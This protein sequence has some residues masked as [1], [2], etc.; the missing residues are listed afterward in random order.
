M[1]KKKLTQERLKELL[2]YDTETGFFTWRKIEVKNQVK[3]GDIAG[4]LS[5]GYVYI[6]VDQ[7]SYR[8]NRLAWLYEYGYFP[9]HEVDHKNRIKND[10][11]ICN[12]REVS[13]QCNMRN[14]DILNTNTSGVTG[15]T[16]CNTFK[17]WRA[18]IERNKKTK[19]LIMGNLFNL[20]TIIMI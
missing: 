5:S 18:K 15:V 10:N 19:I 12:L 4:S 13:H 8:A 7:T 3:V 20:R 14:V 1:S 11:R 6:C 16:F 17:K 2:H 9:E